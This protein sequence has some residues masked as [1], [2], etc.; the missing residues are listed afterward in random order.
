MLRLGSLGSGRLLAAGALGVAVVAVCLGG[1]RMFSPGALNG[2]SRTSTRLGGAAAH[3]DLAN[4]CSACHAPAWSKETMTSRCLDCHTDVRQQLDTH[5]PLHGRMSD[6]MECRRCHTEHNGPHGTLTSLEH[7]DHGWTGFRLTGK[8]RAVDCQS[9]HA[10]QVYKG[11]PQTCVSCHA[12]PASHKGNYG[13]ACASC[14]TTS[15]WERPA[16]KHTFPLTH[17]TRRRQASTCTTCHVRADEFRT[18]TCYGCHEHHPAAMERRHARLRVAELGRCAECHPGGRKGDRRR[19]AE[20]GPGIEVAQQCPL[21]GD[22]CPLAERSFRHDH[23]A[24]AR[25]LATILLTAPPPQPEREP[26]SWS[27]GGDRSIF[28]AR[29]GRD[30]LRLPFPFPPLSGAR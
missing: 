8:H 3:A 23:D 20:D 4:N 15:T 18:Y 5:G 30:L 17:G 22:G 6:G 13:T 29:A 11:T 14:H 21:G 26:L 9:C 25:L 7:F 24:L 16:F 1:G 28:A 10:G 2:Q 27:D 12:E 19:A